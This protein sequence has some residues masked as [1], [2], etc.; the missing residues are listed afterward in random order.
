MRN[1]T[2]GKQLRRLTIVAKKVQPGALCGAK[3][4]DGDRQRCNKKYDGQERQKVEER[5]IDVEQLQCHMMHNNSQKKVG[6]FVEQ[7]EEIM[8][9]LCFS[10]GLQNTQGLEA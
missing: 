10:Y 6:R 9:D 8:P 4:G 3:V 5:Y 2:V 7:R 1:Q